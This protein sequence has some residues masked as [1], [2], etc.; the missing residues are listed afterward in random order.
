MARILITGCSSGIG[1]ASAVAFARSGHEVVATARNPE[2]LADLRDLP[3]VVATLHLDVTDEASVRASL[4]SAGEIDVV[5]NN[6]GY[7]VAGPVELCNVE[8]VRRMFEV[9]YFGV[10]RMVQAFVPRMRHRGHGVFVN[11]S[12]VAGRV[13]GPFTGFY[14]GTKHALEALSDAMHYE[15]GHFGIRTILIEPGAIATNFSANVVHSGDHTPPYDELRQQWD[16]A[17]SRLLGGGEAPGPEL[18]ADAIVGATE[19]ALDGGD[20][21]RRIPVGDD[22]TLV[23][24]LVRSMG[25]A[26]FEA[27][28]RDTLGLDW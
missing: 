16:A 23:I 11:V 8:D 9:N 7:E 28:M 3:G 14:A 19:D 2:D 25:D 5:V 1:R 27:L 12:S 18:V 13:A 17:G 10:V 15:L 24:P 20:G 22:A 6:A 26:E 21:P 4:T